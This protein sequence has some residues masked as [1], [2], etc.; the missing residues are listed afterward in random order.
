MKVKK[1]RF[2]EFTRLLPRA[3]IDNVIARNNDYKKYIITYVIIIEETEEE[4]DL[5]VGYPYYEMDTD[6]NGVIIELVSIKNSFNMHSIEEAEGKHVLT[7]FP[8][9]DWK[10]HG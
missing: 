8:Q 6:A 1:N 10:P 5:G 2:D 7:F 9:L 4:D 3:K